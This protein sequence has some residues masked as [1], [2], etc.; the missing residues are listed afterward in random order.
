MEVILA[1]KNMSTTAGTSPEAIVEI[2]ARVIKTGRSVPVPR[3][4]AR[5]RE[6]LGLPELPDVNTD[7]L[8]ILCGKADQEGGAS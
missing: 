8:A 5:Q 4:V 6:K 7:E 3:S 1:L 2:A